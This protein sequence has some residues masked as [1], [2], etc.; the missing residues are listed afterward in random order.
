M[1]R[2]SSLSL[3]LLVGLLC[4]QPSF[5]QSAI[6]DHTHHGDQGIEKPDQVPVEASPGPI[7]E[8]PPPASAG[9]GP[10]RAADT[11]WGAEAMRPSRHALRK[12]HGDF[13]TLWV[14]MDRLEAQTG[15]GKQ[16]YLWDAQVY[17]GGPTRKIWLKSEGEGR[18]GGG[19]EDAEVQALWSRAIG[20]FWDVQ[21]GARQDLAGPKTSHVA[22]GLQGLAPYMFEVD[23]AVFLSHRGH[24]TARIEAELDQRITQQLILQ[25]RAELN[26]SAQRASALDM[27]RGITKAEL[28]LRLRYEV[29]REFAPY[30]G[31]AQSWTPGALHVAKGD[32]AKQESATYGVAGIRF[33]F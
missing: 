12:M 29:R 20:P 10:P 9:S 26:L 27:R 22:L 14:Q 13:P 1:I 11:I 33:W 28:G 8:T 16:D 18:F 31:I 23:A 19:V 30:I 17:Y 3:V 32:A 4:A 5:G 7:M 21:L 25:P 15:S 24:V 2:R 6:H